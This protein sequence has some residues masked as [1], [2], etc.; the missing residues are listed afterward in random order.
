M[1]AVSCVKTWF[2]GCN[3]LG[4]GLGMSRFYFGAEI[5]DLKASF[6]ACSNKGI[7]QVS[8][9]NPRPSFV[10]SFEARLNEVLHQDYQEPRS[11][12]MESL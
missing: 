6:E 4:L 3:I 2:L 9:K 7:H 11:L 8:Y 5:E 10:L 12:M 1:L